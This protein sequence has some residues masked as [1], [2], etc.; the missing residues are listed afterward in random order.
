MEHS[1]PTDSP[2]LPSKSSVSC[3]AKLPVEI[4][5]IIFRLAYTTKPVAPLSRDFLPFYREAWWESI[6]IKTFDA[7]NKLVKAIEDN[8]NLTIF[9]KKLEINVEQGN[10]KHEVEDVALSVLPK[11]REV[12]L[13]DRHHWVGVRM[14]GLDTGNP[15]LTA[16][17]ILT[18]ATYK[19]G[20]KVQTYLSLFPSLERLSLA[21]Y[22][23]LEA[24]PALLEA[25]P[26]P[27]LL[28]H[29][30][31]DGGR[32][33]AKWAPSTLLASLCSL[34]QLTLKGNYD[35][36]E[37]S[38]FVA[39]RLLPLTVLNLGKTDFI[40]IPNL[41]A[42]VSGPTSHPTLRR[43]VSNLVTA[44]RGAPIDVYDVPIYDHSDMLQDWV[45]P[46]WTFGFDHARLARVLQAAQGGRVK[47]SG[48]A[49][50]AW[51]IEKEYAQQES[52][53]QNMMA[54]SSDGRIIPNLVVLSFSTCSKG[55]KR[56]V[57]ALRLERVQQQQSPF[58]LLNKRA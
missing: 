13:H 51:Q 28:R 11:L 10:K 41:I 5:S 43:L 30:V 50:K 38:F 3:L 53:L 21:P 15:A 18:L 40:S 31:L 25:L 45:L 39:L 17:K 46:K 22:K 12:V 44:K 49:V 33:S 14:Y 55:S 7:L 26:S 16:V 57:T 29:L 27:T 20:P 54:Y 19:S 24:S 23:H 1:E 32:H 52:M 58:L 37:P 47:V 4:S 36:S 48:T 2:L 9:V 42:L 6:E 56:F 34:D 8:Q 35:A